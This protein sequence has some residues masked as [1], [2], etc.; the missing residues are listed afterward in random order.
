MKAGLKVLNMSRKNEFKST[1]MLA[2]DM[3]LI[4]A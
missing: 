3:E 4:K 2:S 1:Y